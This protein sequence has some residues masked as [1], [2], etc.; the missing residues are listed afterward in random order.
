MI[1]NL[2][3]DDF[4]DE[5]RISL[6]GEFCLYRS[7][8]GIDG[9]YLLS[10]HQ[11]PKAGFVN[12]THDQNN[13]VEPTCIW[14]T[15]PVAVGITAF[16]V[17]DFVNLRGLKYRIENDW[18][19][20][21][22]VFYTQYFNN[23]FAQELLKND[24]LPIPDTDENVKKWFIPIHL[25]KERLKLEESKKYFEECKNE[26]DEKLNCKLRGYVDGYFLWLDSQGATPEM[27]P[28]EKKI[29]IQQI[30]LIY[31]YEGWRITRKNGNDIAKDKGQISGEALYQAFSRYS[32]RKK[33]ISI[34][35]SRQ[36]TLNKIKRIEKIISYLSE[37]AQKSAIDEVN[38]L[39]AAL[40]KETF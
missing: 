15:S 18:K 37:A 34:E 6:M 17:R 20:K 13:K 39:K 4:L 29:T 26:E 5:E 36:K 22:K 33:R 32:L 30:A 19:L 11:R 38:T 31:A 28:N 2:R 23:C 3:W 8:R 14:E 40:D 7:Y 9:N 12:A 25:K 21:S 10:R 24:K 16:Y 1:S 27:T 35:T